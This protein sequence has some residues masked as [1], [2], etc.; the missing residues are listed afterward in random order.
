MTQ[1]GGIALALTRIPNELGSYVA[2]PTVATSRWTGLLPANEFTVRAAIFT[3]SKSAGSELKIYRADRRMIIAMCRKKGWA[4]SQAS[5]G[6]K[7]DKM[8]VRAGTAHDRKKIKMSFVEV[9]LRGLLD[10]RFSDAEAEQIFLSFLKN[11]GSPPTFL[12]WVDLDWR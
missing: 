2:P 4:I 9:I 11:V 6:S 3:C 10:G 8:A 7:R 12:G 5:D 1:Y